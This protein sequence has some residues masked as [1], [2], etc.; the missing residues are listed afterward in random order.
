MKGSCWNEYESDY[1]ELLDEVLEVEYVGTTR[2]IVVLFKCTWFNTVGGVRV[3]PKH[4]L[5]DVK[6]KPRL[7]TDDPFILASQVHYASYPSTAW[8]LKDWWAVVKTKPRGIYEIAECATGVADN[9]NIDGDH[10]FQED[11]RPN[12]S[13]STH[14]DEDIESISL[15]TPGSPIAVDVNEVGEDED[16]EEEEFVDGTD[17][18]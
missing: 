3:D 17:S 13:T 2:C 6:Y 12:F 7:R 5:V 16:E 10:F 1:Y 9:D 11:D 8:E 14:I 18:N 15:V 4:N